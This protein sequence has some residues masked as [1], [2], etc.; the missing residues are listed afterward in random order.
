MN[1]STVAM[2]ISVISLVFSALAFVN[3]REAARE[4]ETKPIVHEGTGMWADIGHIKIDMDS[5]FQEYDY[6]YGL[7]AGT[8]FWESAHTTADHLALKRSTELSDPVQCDAGLS[9]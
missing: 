3:N 4:P 7:I 6:K 5:V 1:S 8:G 9:C 2:G